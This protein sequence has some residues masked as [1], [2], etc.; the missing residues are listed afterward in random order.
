MFQSRLFD[1]SVTDGDEYAELLDVEV[2]RVLDIHAPLRTGRRHSG[3]HDN[4]RLSDEASG[5]T[6]GLA[7]S[8]TDY[9]SA[10]SAAR[11]CNLKSRADRVKSELDE[12]SGDISERHRDCYTTTILR[13]VVYDRRLVYDD[14]EYAQLV[15]TFCKFFVDKVN[16]I[17]NNISEALQTS[18]SR[19]FAA[20]PHRGPEISAFE[21]VTEHGVRRLL[22]SIP[23]KSSQLDVLPCSL[24]KTCTDVFAPAREG[25]R[26][27]HYRLAYFQHATSKHI[28]FCHC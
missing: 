4:R 11:D 14:T 2:K 3:Q 28:L 23:A 27:C 25:S 15:S 1:F 9:L 24:L 20:R 8:R 26:T 5:D 10:C 7:W 22:R 6:A 19:V 21:P 13:V 16:Q 17:R 12:V 18:A